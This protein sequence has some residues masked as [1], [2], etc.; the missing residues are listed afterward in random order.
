MWVI[1]TEEGVSLRSRT[2]VIATGTFMRGVIHIGAERRE[3]GRVGDK[4][5]IGISDQLTEHGFKVTRLKTGTPPRLDKKTI[6]WSQT[7]PQSGDDD[8]IPFSFQSE[9][10][11]RLPQIDCYLTSTN[12]RTHEIIRKNLCQSPLFSGAIEGIGPRYCPSIEDKI[13]RFKDKKQ[14]LSFLEP[15]GLKSSSIYL[16]GISTS[17]PESVQYEF[18]RTIP[19][20]QEVKMLR[21]GYAVEY[22]FFEPRQNL[23]QFRDQKY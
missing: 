21:P 10:K 11:P 5:T 23:S 3:G 4:A 22:D 8:F 6:D 9:P 20:L 15:E 18:L 13:T 7:T 2:V 19:G 12:E 17:L 14:H 1:V 16:Q